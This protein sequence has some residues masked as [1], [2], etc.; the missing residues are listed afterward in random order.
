[1]GNCV[2]SNAIHDDSFI[3]SEI[4]IDDN[5]KT[6]YITSEYSYKNNIKCSNYI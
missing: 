4:V 1:M 2:S 6:Y 3:H 5:N